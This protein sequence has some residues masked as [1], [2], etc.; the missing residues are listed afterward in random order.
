[1]NPEKMGKKYKKPK[2]PPL[3]KELELSRKGLISDTTCLGLG[4]VS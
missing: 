4:N 3:V 2:A 1:M